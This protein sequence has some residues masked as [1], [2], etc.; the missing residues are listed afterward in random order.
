[1]PERSVIHAAVPMAPVSAAGSGADPDH[2]RGETP[3]FHGD[4]LCY[5]RRAYAH[6][7]TGDL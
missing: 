3:S 7:A 1:M 6:S 2:R 4:G 5:K